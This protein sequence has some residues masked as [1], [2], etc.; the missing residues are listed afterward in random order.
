MH[1]GDQAGQIG[2]W[3]GVAL[4]I[5]ADDRGGEAGQQRLGSVN[6]VGDI[7][8]WYLRSPKSLIQLMLSYLS[9]L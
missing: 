4:D 7:L 2:G 1:R 5:G 6:G 3:H 9:Y 8:F